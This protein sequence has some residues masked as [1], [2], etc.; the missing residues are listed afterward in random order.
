MRQG[1]VRVQAAESVT[2]GNPQVSGVRV[3]TGCTTR[4][5]L[6]VDNTGLLC[7]EM[8]EVDAGFSPGGG[9]LM[10]SSERAPL[11]FSPS[12]RYLPEKRTKFELLR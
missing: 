7:V 1:C 12:L 9:K 10:H 11:I 8:L 3:R 6:R 2:G 5:L 4:Y